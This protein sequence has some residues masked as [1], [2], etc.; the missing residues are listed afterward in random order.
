VHRL[1]CEE[2]LATA[3][4]IDPAREDPEPP[5]IRVRWNG[6]TRWWCTG[7]PAQHALVRDFVRKLDVLD[8]GELPPLRLLQVRAADAQAIARMLMDQYDRRSQD[9]R[10]EKPVDRPKA[11]GADEHADRVGPRGPVR[12]GPCVRRGLEHR[13]DARKRTGSRRSTR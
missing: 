12:G 7:E 13:G 10:R 2:F 6:R 1:R 8:R 11:D 5:I 9:D 4:S 3:D